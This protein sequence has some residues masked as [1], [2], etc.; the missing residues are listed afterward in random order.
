MIENVQNTVTKKENTSKNEDVIILVERK[1][2]FFKDVIQKTIL[3]VQKNKSLDILGVSDVTAGTS[4]TLRWTIS[5]GSCSDST[6]TVVLTNYAS[7]TTS[8]AGPDSTQ[9]DTE[10]FTLSGNTQVD[11]NETKLVTPAFRADSMTLVLIITLSYKYSPLYFILPPRP[12]TFPA[13]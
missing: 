3:H 2:D 4:A 10:T 6:D 11:K 9:C 12:P 13:Q 7:P 1:I 8:D 5:N